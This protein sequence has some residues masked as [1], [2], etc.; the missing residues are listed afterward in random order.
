[1]IEIIIIIREL[2][3]AIFIFM[4]A[5]SSAANYIAYLHVKRYKYYKQVHSVSL[6]QSFLGIFIGSPLIFVPFVFAE[7]DKGFL[8]YKKVQN[9]IF[10]AR[11][12]NIFLFLNTI[13]FP[14]KFF[15]FR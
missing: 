9:S 6:E 12:L 7:S 5:I 11:I 15:F 4:I 8:K 13:Y 3:F 14:M 10:W 2:I 1:M